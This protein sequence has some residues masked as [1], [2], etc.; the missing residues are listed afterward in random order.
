MWTY[1]EQQKQGLT[2]W[3]KNNY[4][5]QLHILSF[6]LLVVTDHSILWMYNC[7]INGNIS[8]YFLR[9]FGCGSINNFYC[10]TQ[11][12]LSKKKVREHLVS[13]HVN[14]RLNWLTVSRVLVSV[15][16]YDLSVSD[17]VLGICNVKDFTSW[18][19]SKHPSNWNMIL[20]HSFRIC[21]TDAWNPAMNNFT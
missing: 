2:G 5:L 16:T 21:F 14:F 20:H 7:L 15:A 6:Y 4:L 19:N 18:S 12:I 13:K 11:V 3:K 9:N 8:G 17:F 1:E 10:T